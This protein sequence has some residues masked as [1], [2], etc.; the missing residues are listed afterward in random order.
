MLFAF[1][2]EVRSQRGGHISQNLAELWKQ[3]KL[4]RTGNKDLLRN[5][6]G[7]N[8]EKLHDGREIFVIW[9]R[10]CKLSKS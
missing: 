2:T 4:R 1:H 9:T 6:H 8:D 3:V 5:A 7:K 10:S